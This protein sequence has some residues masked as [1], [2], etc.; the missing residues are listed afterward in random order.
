VRVVTLCPSL[1]LLRLLISRRLNVKL[2]T[3][4]DGTRDRPVNILITVQLAW[5]AGLAYPP[6]G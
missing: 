4:R 5:P 2:A 1:T 6:C 3:L